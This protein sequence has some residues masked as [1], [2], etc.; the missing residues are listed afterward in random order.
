MVVP[1]YSGEFNVPAL[2][3]LLQFPFLIIQLRLSKRKIQL[4]L[5]GNRKNI[6]ISAPLLASATTPHLNGF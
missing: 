3:Y 6:F 1:V 2:L 4:L 5:K